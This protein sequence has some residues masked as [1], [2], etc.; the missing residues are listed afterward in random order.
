MNKEIDKTVNK[1]KSPNLG[2]FVEIMIVVASIV[3][4]YSCYSCSICANIPQAMILGVTSRPTYCSKINYINRQKQIHGCI[5]THL[6]IHTYTYIYIHTYTYIYT[7][8]ETHIHVYI[9]IHM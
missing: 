5:Y 9:H 2:A 4:P 1:M 3:V 7:H 8:T 6:N